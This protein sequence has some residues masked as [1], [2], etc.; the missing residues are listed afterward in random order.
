MF[1]CLYSYHGELDYMQREDRVAR[2][3]DPRLVLPGVRSVIMVGMMY[4][5][6]TTGFPG[7]HHYPK[8]SAPTD[9]NNES[10]ARARGI[11]SSYAWG[12]DYHVELSRRLRTLG[13]HLN[14]VAGG[15]GRF[16]VDTGAVLERDFAERAGLG[17]IGKNSLLINPQVGSGFFIGELFSTI[18]LPLDHDDADDNGEAADTSSEPRRRQQL[19]KRK[20]GQPGCGRCTRCKDACPTGAIVEDHVVDARRCISY[21]TIELKGKIPEELRHGIGNRVYG[22]DICQIVCPWNKFKWNEAVEGTKEKGQGYSPLFGHV[23][24]KVSTPVLVELLESDEETFE[25]KFRGSA[26]KRIGRDRMARNAAVALGN[27]GGANE[28]DALKR[29]A[30]CD[31]SEMVREHAAWAIG[32]IGKN[33]EKPII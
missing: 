22:C 15:V 6:G 24:E 13:R 12:T 29:V 26:I 19:R 32:Q 33:M 14:S 11:I 17:F 30:L 27:V 2:R 5:P 18:P 28:L 7:A 10:D 16:Y 9:V 8:S 23:G 21:L 31:R 4:W 3:E 1:G 20:A 25:E